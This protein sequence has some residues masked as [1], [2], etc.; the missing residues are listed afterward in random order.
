MTLLL[1]GA[2]YGRCASIRLSRRLSS[3]IP[4][5]N[6]VSFQR[7]FLSTCAVGWQ[8]CPDSD[9]PP[10]VWD[11]R[12]HRFSVCPWKDSSGNTVRPNNLWWFNVI[13]LLPR[14][15]PCHR[16]SLKVQ[17][18]PIYHSLLH[19]SSLA[20]CAQQVPHD[21]VVKGSLCQFCR[22]KQALC[23]SGTTLTGI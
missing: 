13:K 15:H 14:Q 3:F 8:H 16:T 5:S 23:S 12:S 22:W 17:Q 21:K 1:L 10:L 6:C 18:E 4:V 7:Y 19:F 20:V 2:E 11:L 9:R